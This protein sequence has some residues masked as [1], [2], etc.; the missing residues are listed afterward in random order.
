MANIT[1]P[2]VIRRPAGIEESAEFAITKAPMEDLAAIPASQACVLSQV[3]SAQPRAPLT[4]G[5]RAMSKPPNRKPRAI[6]RPP[7]ATNGIM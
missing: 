2:S 5:V 1:A 7:A 3:S 6:S 4:P